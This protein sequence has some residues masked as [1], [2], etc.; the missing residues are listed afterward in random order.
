MRAQKTL[1]LPP[2]LRIRNGKLHYRFMVAGAEYSASTG[3]AAIERNLTPALRSLSRARLL[4]ESG[5][6]DQL[7]VSPKP[8]N[9]AAAVFADWATGEYSEHPS[10]ARRIGTSLVSLEAFFGA[11]PIHS[12]TAGNVEEYKAWR[13]KAGIR[14]ITLRHDLHALSRLYQFAVKHRW[15]LRN[16]VRSVSIPSEAGAVRQN[17]LTRDDEALY[18]GGLI[19]GSTL[20]DAARLMLLTGMRPSEVL[21]LTRNDVDA[22]RK[23]VTIRAGKSRAARRTLTLVAEAYQIASRRAG[24]SSFYLFA[25]RGGGGMRQLNSAHDR[26]LAKINGPDEAGNRPPREL[27]VVLYDLRHTFASRMS[28][29]GCPDSTLAAILGHANTRTLG[30]YVHP[31]QEAIDAAMVRFQRSEIRPGQTSD[32]GVSEGIPTGLAGRREGGARRP[33]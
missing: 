29:A 20:Y 11:A 2:G 31:S 8:F 3:Y 18:F 23:T 22:D 19:P 21:A 28:E 17:V 25:G 15:C 1:V 9:D 33:N 16:L 26:H 5:Q 14:E 27:H 6:S 12:I 32:G 24:G 10:S 4:V 7:K 30:R 13:R